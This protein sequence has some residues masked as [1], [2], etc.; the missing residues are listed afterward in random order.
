MK[1]KQD[2]K[3]L[4]LSERI[5]ICHNYYTGKMTLQELM[6][7]YDISRSTAEC[8]VNTHMDDKG[9]YVGRSKKATQHLKIQPK[10]E[11]WQPINIPSQKK[12]LISNYGRIKSFAQDSKEGKI[13]KGKLIGGFL[14]FDYLD[15]K[16][17]KRKTSSLIHVL[18][19]KHFKKKPKGKTVLAHLDY[20]KYNNRDSNLQWMTCTELHIHKTQGPQY[21]LKNSIYNKTPIEKRSSYRFG[22]L[23]VFEVRQIKKEL[24]VHK[25][26][27]IKDIANKFNIS[28][29]HVERISR[30][31]NWSH[32]LP[33]LV[34]AK[35][36]DVTTP[37]HLVN[38]VVMALKKNIITQKSI[39]EKYGLTETTVSRIK[40]RNIYGK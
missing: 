10:N 20:N 37:K 32:I 2:K 40:K 7:A 14:A 34:R 13:L 4:T 11:R 17:G 39:A 30:G 26:L 27:R 1:T 31:D 12:F 8:Y 21:K 19:A 9:R 5:H 16:D 25:R 24:F 28:E 15:K 36:A 3:R 18:V 6:K 23:S 33:N 38:K 29:M 22:K 35:N